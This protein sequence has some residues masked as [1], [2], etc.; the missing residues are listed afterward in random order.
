[1]RKEER[2]CRICGGEEKKWEHLLERCKR[3]GDEKE[4]EVGMY[5]RGES[6]KINVALSL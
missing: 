6:S 3:G 1:M 4:T 2:L 5:N